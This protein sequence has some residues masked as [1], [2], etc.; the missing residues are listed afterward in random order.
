MPN[1]INEPDHHTTRAEVAT[2][3]TRVGQLEKGMNT[4]GE[5]LDGL[6][7][8]FSSRGQTNW[9]HIIS[10]GSLLTAVL[11]LVGT[12]VYLP[13]KDSQIRA[14][15]S[16]LALSAKTEA[17]FEKVISRMELRDERIMSQI[18][19]RQEHELFWKNYDRTIERVV[20]RLDRIEF[21]AEKPGS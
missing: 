17:T 10:A 19:P 9:Q 3:G 18:V 21:K 6:M 4:I 11:G 20:K 13:I 16:I 1:A 8:L 15:V 12:V 2:L 5:K 7:N 14:E